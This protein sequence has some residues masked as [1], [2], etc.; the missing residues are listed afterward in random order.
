MISFLL[1]SLI[2][3]FLGVLLT[4]YSL[5]EPPLPPTI[6]VF[7]WALD[8]GGPVGT[9]SNRQSLP[10]VLEVQRGAVLPYQC[11]TP[12]STSPSHSLNKEMS[13]SS[14]FR[15]SEPRFRPLWR[16][17]EKVF[18]FPFVPVQQSLWDCIAVPLFT[19]RKSAIRVCPGESVHFFKK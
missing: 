14:L 7:S 4:C 1:A 11:H 19:P 5:L 16:C 2:V 17:V 10:Y 9:C 18:A 15:R 3:I 6:V 12:Q 13:A 8:E